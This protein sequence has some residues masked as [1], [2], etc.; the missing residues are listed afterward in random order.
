MASAMDGRRLQ[1]RCANHSPVTRRRSIFPARVERALQPPVRRVEHGVPFIHLADA[2][3][4]HGGPFLR[5]LLAAGDLEEHDAEAVDVGIGAAPP[6]ADELR[7]HVPDSP[8][9]A[10]TCV[11]S[12][13]ASWSASLDSSKSPG[14]V[15][16]RK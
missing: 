15:Y 7:V 14:D 4:E 2:S 3:L 10:T 9:P 12:G 1:S 11:V 6:V 13:S 5:R 8:V 16:C